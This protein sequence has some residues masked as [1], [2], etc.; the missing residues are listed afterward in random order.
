MYSFK[1]AHGNFGDDL[2]DW[3][4]PKL[5]GS[6]MALLP[7]TTFVGIGS[8][9]DQ[10]LNK[11]PGPKIVFGS[12]IRSTKNLPG[13]SDTLHIRFVRGPISGLA[14][15]GT[16]K[17]ITDPAILV[18]PL[19]SKPAT[20]PS[21]IGLMPHYHSLP[22]MSWP[23]VAEELGLLFIDPRASVDETLALLGQCKS[24][25]TEAMHGAIV[26]DALRIPW[27]RISFHAWRKEGFD[28]SS[29]K[30][31]DWGLSAQ[32]DV[33]PNHL[34]SPSPK[35]SNLLIRAAVIARNALVVRRATNAL[36]NLL[37]KNEYQL[38]DDRKHQE[39]LD[40]TMNEVRELKSWLRY[41]PS[42]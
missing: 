38:S 36:H 34:P 12:G 21:M 6:D 5:L 20:P 4:W 11:I 31:L 14:L 25:V 3:M 23:K 42:E 33:T 27:T 17:W 24:V 32:V 37:Q 15:G 41:S 1:A 40:K 22:L 29:L 35:P 9:L 26:A 28:V 19:I 7:T 30:W 8:I 10:R 16:T 13:E 39:L 2:N 18:R